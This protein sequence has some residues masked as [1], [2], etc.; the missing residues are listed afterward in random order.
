MWQCHVTT[1]TFSHT[2][3]HRL[4]T[5]YT[6]ALKPVLSL[7]RRYMMRAWDTYIPAPAETEWCLHSWQRQVTLYN[8][9][10]VWWERGS[11]LNEVSV[12]EGW[13]VSLAQKKGQSGAARTTLCEPTC[14]TAAP[15]SGIKAL[16][17]MYFKIRVWTRLC[18]YKFSN[19]TL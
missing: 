18:S 11:R 8:N 4:T 13:P 9:R 15:Y 17:E 10:A 2:P 7:L 3:G 14:Q 16:T 19:I 1:S 6:N 12:N 5:L